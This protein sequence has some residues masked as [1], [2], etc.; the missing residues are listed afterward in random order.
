[1]TS[2]ADVLEMFVVYFNTQDYPSRYVVRR[3]LCVA[4]EPRP[5][6]DVQ[7]FATLEEARASLSPTLCRLE[8]HPNDDPVIV[9]TWV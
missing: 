1:M 7:D 3:W 9:E 6:A 4:P 2:S 5:T 8:R